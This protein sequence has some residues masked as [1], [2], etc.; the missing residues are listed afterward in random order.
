LHLLNA[1]PGGTE[2]AAQ[3]GDS[4]Q[5]TPLADPLEAASRRR[6]RGNRRPPVPG[7]SAQ[8]HEQRVSNLFL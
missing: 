3:V 5:P 1:A 7:R 6:E 4:R 8:A 2:P